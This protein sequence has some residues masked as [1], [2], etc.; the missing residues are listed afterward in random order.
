MQS[1]SGFSGDRSQRIVGPSHLPADGRRTT[2]GPVS[3]PPRGNREADTSL[4]KWLANGCSDY[5]DET[6]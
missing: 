3:P 6:H 2:I 1:Q 5:R 4:A